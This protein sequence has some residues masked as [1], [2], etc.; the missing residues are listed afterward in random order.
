MTRFF[1]PKVS[2]TGLLHATG[3]LAGLCTVAG[4]LASS[5]WLIELT[6]HFRLQYALVLAA[7]A[8][9]THMLAGTTRK[10]AA[11][12]TGSAKQPRWP[13]LVYAALAL[14][15]LAVLI[16]SFAPPAQR[17]LPAASKQW[18][19][20]TVNVHTANPRHDLV[21]AFLR[22]ED[23]DAILLIEVDAR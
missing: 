20:V 14:S 18:R 9:L 16:P 7:A 12:A 2:V 1:E 23:P 22:R 6:C 15:N 13:S 19:V 4:F 21:E 8:L 17:P 5:S 10:D 11:P 3:A